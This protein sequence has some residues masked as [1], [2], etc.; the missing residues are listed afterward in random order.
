MTTGPTTEVSS[1][2]LAGIILHKDFIP[3]DRIAQARGV[4]YTQE[5]L[6]R[7]CDTLPTEEDLDWCR[8]NDMM[9]LAG[10]PTSMSLVEVNGLQGNRF[11]AI[12]DRWYTYPKAKKRE[13]FAYEDKVGPVWFAL[14]KYPLKGSLD[15]NL[16][17]Q[18]GCV[19]D[20]MGV[21]NIAELVWGLT[22]YCAVNDVHL[23]SD[24]SVRTSSVA[25]DGTRP[26]AGNF[27]DSGFSI[28][29]YWDDKKSPDLGIA[30]SRKFG[31]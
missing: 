20:P 25:S 30:G 11:P 24:M 1:Y 19:V 18:G 17:D 13:D 4:T 29:P 7:L 2:E 23:L 22:A 12:V 27:N 28:L 21:P 26:Y 15:K 16:P 6:E 5:Q 8:A 14:S 9:L 31:A 10:P 3:P